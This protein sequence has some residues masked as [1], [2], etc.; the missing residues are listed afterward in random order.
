MAEAFRLQREVSRLIRRHALD[1]GEEFKGEFNAGGTA[2]IEHPSRN[3]DVFRD[4]LLNKRRQSI[5]NI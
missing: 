3:T 4:F 2:D 1:A 5:W